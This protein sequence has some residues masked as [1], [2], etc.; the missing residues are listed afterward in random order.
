MSAGVRLLYFP[1]CAPSVRA[2]QRT[3]DPLVVVRFHGGALERRYMNRAER[4]HRSGRA[5]LRV[6]AYIKQ[7]PWHNWD[8][9]E[10]LLGQHK[11]H[12][13][14]EYVF[15]HCWICAW[16]D[17]ERV[18]RQMV[19]ADDRMKDELLEAC[20]SGLLASPAKG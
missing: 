17:R 7:S 4:R 12:L 9:F 1:L 2:A 6:I 18:K 16:N 13:S 20:Q 10:A 14:K 5:K 15:C 3:P 19:I 11:R 8:S